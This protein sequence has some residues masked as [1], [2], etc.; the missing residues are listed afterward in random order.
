MRY[1]RRK[2]P[3]GPL[4]ELISQRA[5]RT[6]GIKPLSRAVGKDAADAERLRRAMFRV[7]ASSS[8]TLRTVDEISVALGVHPSA[9]YPTDDDIFVQ[10]YS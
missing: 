6:G 7:M 1:S 5:R 4:Q 9:I 2:R 8:V 3:A 10:V